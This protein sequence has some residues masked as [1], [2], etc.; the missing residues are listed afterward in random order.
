M[1]ETSA[2]RQAPFVLT[3]LRYA[4]L[5]RRY[6]LQPVLYIRP[7]HVGTGDRI[8]PGISFTAKVKRQPFYHITFAAIPMGIFSLLA[9]LTAAGRRVD[10][11]NHRAHLNMILLLTASTYRIASGR[12]LP[13]INYLT[14]ELHALEFLLLALLRRSLGP[15]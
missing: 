7:H 1:R 15:S 14:S 8:F 5:L 2:K 11:L 13:A 3:P 6:A 12:G 10:S 9:V 4:A